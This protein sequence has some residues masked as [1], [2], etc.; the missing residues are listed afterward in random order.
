[1]SNDTGNSPVTL[2]TDRFGDVDGR[3]V[4]RHTLANRQGMSLSILTYGGIIQK[5]VVPDRHGRPGNVALGFDNLNDYV[6]KS[7]YFGAIVGRYANR[8]A[9][10]R[11]TLNGT[12]FQVPVNNGPNSLHGGR[13]GFD[14]QVWTAL[15]RDN[16]GIPGLVLSLL[17]PDGDEGYPGN[18]VVTVTYSLSPDN[19]LSIAYEATTDAPTAVNLSNH[20]YFNLA[21]EGS[22]DILRHA[23][24]LHASRYTP[25]GE[26]LIPTGEIAPVAGTP[27]DFTEARVI[28]ERIGQAGD[29]QLA[30]AGGYDHNFVIDRDAAE[31]TAMV[32]IARVIDPAS[33][34]VLDVAT[35][36]PGVQF[37][38]GNFLDGTFAGTSG[39]VYERRSGFCLETQHFP[40]SPNQPGFPS[41]VL[42]PGDV[43]RSVTTFT[44]GVLP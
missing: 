11:F 41:T 27:F 14:R 44:F 12:E 32:Q 16:A 17:S 43:F 38:T 15:I 37:Y 10:G 22:G 33:G 6:E 25:V 30:I 18:L 2:T 4:E 5:L 7:P 3:V 36:Q 29:P 28:G 40:D 31:P 9:G 35:D 34:R 21:G 20:S 19:V 39:R 24:Q 23:L 26:T 13:K 8:I 42:Q 1:M